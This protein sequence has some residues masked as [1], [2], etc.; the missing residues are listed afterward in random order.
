MAQ[1]NDSAESATET[2]GDDTSPDEN[3]HPFPP[4]E[5]IERIVDELVRDAICVSCEAHFTT[6]RAERR[7]CLWCEASRQ[8]QEARSS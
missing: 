8:I 4:D 1:S 3:E 7:H 6:A 5:E 2:A